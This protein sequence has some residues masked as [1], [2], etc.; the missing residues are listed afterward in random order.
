LSG[1]ALDPASLF[2]LHRPPGYY[3]ADEK[4]ALLRR[5]RKSPHDE[6]LVDFRGSDVQFKFSAA[7]LPL[8]HGAWS[9]QATV[10]GQ[11]LGASGAWEES[12]WNRDADC[13]YLELSL[14][15]TG[16]WRLDRQLLL[17]RKD[18][19][20]YLADALVGPQSSDAARGEI[21][22]AASLPLAPRTTF[23]PAADAREAWLNQ[24]GKRRA[25]LVPPALAEWR[26]EFC[27]AE[28]A[29][30]QGHV[31]LSQAALGQALY[32]PLFIDLDP[33]RVRRGLT[34]RRLTVA[35]NLVVVPRDVAAAFRVQV[36]HEQ[37]L[38]YR[39]LAPRG[40]RT[41]LGQNYSSEFV[42]T[43]FLPSGEAKDILAVE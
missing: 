23:V 13:D 33:L 7:G 19:F 36:G 20:L 27:H 39:S 34:W 32:A 14:K 31:V 15:L 22:F 1:R 25:T 17:A 28:L 35:E 38:F 8:I 5:E 11:P 24:G 12:C 41:F 30:E 29:S 40:N 10:A 43:R 18:R 6:A 26:A 9:W 37:W 21:H 16:G 4:V 2:D 3:N 42:C